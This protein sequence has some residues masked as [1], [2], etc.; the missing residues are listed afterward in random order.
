MK[1]LGAFALGIMLAGPAMALDLDNMS[2]AERQSFEAA[3]RAYLLEHPEV[4][5]EAVDVYEQRQASVSAMADAELIRANAEA[6]FND[7]V[8][9]IGGNPAGDITVVEFLDYR[10][11]YCKKAFDEVRELIE[12]DGNI[13]FIVKELPILGEESLLGARFAIAVRTVAGAEAYAAVH[14]ELMTMRSKLTQAAL[15]RIAKR[16]RLDMDAIEAAME[17]EAT[18]AE[19]RANYLLAQQLGINGTP[20]FVFETEMQRGYAPLETMKATVA[21][22]RG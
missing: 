20:G 10:C 9:W 7:G 8:S 17:A 19:I 22:V 21:R 16:H 13:R 11:G 14:D 1:W 15:N 6:I 3:V 2:D 12:R 4:I 5:F 18:D